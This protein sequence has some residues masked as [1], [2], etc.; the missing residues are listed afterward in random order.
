MYNRN[1]LL[2]SFSPIQSQLLK[3]NSINKIVYDWN[4]THQAI[5][6]STH[7]YALWGEEDGLLIRNHSLRNKKKIVWSFPTQTNR[8]PKSLES[9]KEIFSFLSLKKKDKEN[10]QNELLPV[11]LPKIKSTFPLTQVILKK[12]FFF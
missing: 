12:V 4:G 7:E 3:N 9:L 6:T 1:D 11:I 5:I 8:T 2:Q 10:L